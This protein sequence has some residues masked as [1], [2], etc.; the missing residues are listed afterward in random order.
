MVVGGR[1]A[2]SGGR[3][4]RT[5]PEGGP[6]GRVEVAEC[7]GGAA[8]EGFREFIGGGGGFDVPGSGGGGALGGVISVD[9]LLD[10]SG[11]SEFGRW[12]GFRDGLRR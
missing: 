11:I 3:G 6:I 4:A 1:K 5:G 10:R 7:G 8:E 12:R 9:A 2:D